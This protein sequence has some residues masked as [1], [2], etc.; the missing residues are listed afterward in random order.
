MHS[1][2]NNQVHSDLTFLENIKRYTFKSAV[3]DI[4]KKRPTT[5]N[6]ASSEAFLCHLSD[7]N[8]T[9]LQAH[10][11]RNRLPFSVHRRKRYPVQ[12]GALYQNNQPLAS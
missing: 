5:K 6:Q 8:I 3:V 9:L 7:L 12:H 2:N 10:I 4:L 11:T 1:E